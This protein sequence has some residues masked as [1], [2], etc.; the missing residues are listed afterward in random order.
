MHDLR[1]SFRARCT[2]MAAHAPDETTRAT[3]LWPLTTDNT[4][5]KLAS[6]RA[7]PRLSQQSCYKITSGYR[8]QPS[9]DRGRGGVPLLV[10]SASSIRARQRY[11]RNAWLVTACR[12]G[13]MFSGRPPSRLI[14][15][16]LCWYVHRLLLELFQSFQPFSVLMCTIRSEMSWFLSP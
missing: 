4:A 7:Y 14:H 16:L 6:P 11:L 10:S 8:G 12:P 13:Q 3:Q 5:S 1:Q 15:N 2:G 9:G